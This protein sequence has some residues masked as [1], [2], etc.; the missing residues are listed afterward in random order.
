MI[1]L[2]L[3]LNL[4]GPL[5]VIT[6]AHTGCIWKLNLAQIKVHVSGEEMESCNVDVNKLKRN[7]VAQRLA[8]IDRVDNE[9]RHPF[10]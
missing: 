10:R 1:Y 5:Q 2:P 4:R 3:P 9:M 6:L 8:D 7:I